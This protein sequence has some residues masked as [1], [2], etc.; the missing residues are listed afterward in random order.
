MHGYYGPPSAD[1]PSTSPNI[2]MHGYYGPVP[3]WS[4][5]FLPFPAVNQYPSNVQNASYT[6]QHG[7]ES[8]LS[9]SNTYVTSRFLGTEDNRPSVGE[10]ESPATSSRVEEIHPD[11]PD[12]E[13]I[14][15]GSARTSEK[16]QMDGDDEPV[17]GMEFNSL[18]D[19]MS[20]YEEYGQ[21]RGFGV[22]T[23]RSE[24]GED[25][26]V[27]YV[28]IACA[29]GGKAR[30]RTINVA[31]PRLTG[32][33]KCKAKINALKVVDGKFRLTTIH[34]IHNHRV[35][36]LLLL[37]WEVLRTSH[38]WKKDCR[39]Y[40]DK[41]RHLR[42]S[43]GGEGAL[44]DY[45]LRMQFNN[46][47]FVALMDLDDEGRLK[48]IFWADPRSR[49]VAYQ[50]FGDVVT[51]DTTYLTNRYGMPFAS[52]VGV[53]H[54]GQSILLGAAL[55]SSEDTETFVWLF[56]TWLQCMDGI[57]PKA[58]ITDQDRAMKNAIAIVFPESRH[59]FCLWHILKKV[60]ERLG[61][62]SSYK[63]GMKTAL[64][65][66]VY[67]TQTPD[68]FEKYWNQLIS[69]YSLHENV[70]LQSLYTEREHWVPAFLKNVFWTGMSIMQRRE[71]M[72]AFFDGYVHAYTNLKEFVDQYD[73]A[74]KKKIENENC[75]DFQEVQQQLTGIID[76]DP[77]LLKVDATV[78]TY[79]VEDEVHVEDF[80][81]LVTHSVDFS[82]DDAVAKCTCGLFEMRG[83]V[84]R[85]IFAVFKCNGIKTI[86]DRYILDRWRKDIK[87]R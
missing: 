41:A 23:K 9:L 61:C 78:K 29:R 80:T 60:S 51:F 77:V 28:T 67:D 16:V 56:Q 58:I 31:N 14:K 33:T 73:N 54:H 32:K 74:L 85:Y 2:P 83:I 5:G 84:C 46:L 38:F 10:T 13:E 75:T 49:V 17:S 63:T 24:R 65:K 37:A 62:Y 86:P 53:N 20:Y 18:E 39:N 44:R 45:F 42:L 55:I 3:T 59:R 50:Y 57:A 70:W 21:K 22:M 15:C 66:S 12:A 48:N 76:L 34:N 27:R 81:K 36:G 1:I 26:T 87:R 52:F 19:L 11:R 82:E 72:N 79:L 4:P 35:S 43:V 30:N 7:M 68:E 6:F 47:G 71:S 64:I 69:T 25:Q 8:Q 40:I